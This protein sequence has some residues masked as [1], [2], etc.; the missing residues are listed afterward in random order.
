MDSFETVVAAILQRKGYWTQTSVKVDLTK[1]EKRRIGRHS[2]P[3]WEL[4]VVAYNG[5]ANELLVVECKSFL[6]SSG[7]GCDVFQRKT[8]KGAKRYKLFFEPKLRR[9]VLNRLRQ[10][11]VKAGFCASRPSVVLALAAGKVKGDE[12]WLEQHFAR[13]GWRFYGPGMLRNQ[14]AALQES[15]YENNVATVV[16]KILL[17]KGKSTA[18]NLAMEPTARN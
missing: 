16:T 18:S 3:R 10:Q 15:K 5:R 17:R 8:R 6:D 14:L 4:D 7:V 2:S 13:N 9:V 12:A 1:A 11:F